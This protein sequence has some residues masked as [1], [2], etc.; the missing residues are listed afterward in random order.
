MKLVV[1]THILCRTQILR[2]DLNKARILLQ[3]F[4]EEFQTYYG[5]ANMVLNVHLLLHNVSC[6]E[7]CGSMF[8]YSNYCTEDFIGHLISLVRGNTD[9]L[10]QI[11]DRYLLEKNLGLQI[12]ESTRVRSF[13]NI[14]EYTHFSNTVQLSKFLLIGKRKSFVKNVENR[15]IFDH[16]NCDTIDTYRAVFVNSNSY[17]E[18]VSIRKKKTYDSFVCNPNNQIYAEIDAIL[19]AN[20]DVY[21]LINNKYKV[22]NSRYNES[23]ALIELEEKQNTDVLLIKA[24]IIHSKFSLM[25][26][27]TMITCAAFPNTFERN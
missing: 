14:L 12:N 22:R 13:Y 3:T 8:E 23:P 11:C 21:M 17:Y 7:R 18:S 19:V 27:N 25:I 6:V 9:I 26:S 2:L 16:C 1:A 20:N 24:S 5:A 15:W 4:V 10:N